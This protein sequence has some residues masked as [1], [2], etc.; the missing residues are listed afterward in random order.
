[1][2]L[3][4]PSAETCDVMKAELIEYLLGPAFL[5]HLMHSFPVSQLMEIGASGD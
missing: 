1:M 4:E 5:K 3:L 2:I